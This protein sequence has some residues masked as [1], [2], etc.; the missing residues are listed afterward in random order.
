MMIAVT[1]TIAGE[2]KTFVSINL[3]GV[4][5]FSGKRVVVVDLDMRKPKIHLGFG[6]E[7]THGMSTLLIGKDSLDNCIRHSAL[8]GLDFITAGPIPPTPAN[9]SSAPPWAS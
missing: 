2:G 1:S 3:G 6:V 9:S 4:I 8:P 7:N 5:S